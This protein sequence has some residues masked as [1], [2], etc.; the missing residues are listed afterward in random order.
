MARRRSLLL[1]YTITD[2][3]RG[4][5]LDQHSAA[6]YDD[7]ATAFGT[8]HS[9]APADPENDEDGWL[10]AGLQRFRDRGFVS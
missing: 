1:N 5:L 6:R 10:D 7:A 4:L 8:R 3:D 2:E 9:A